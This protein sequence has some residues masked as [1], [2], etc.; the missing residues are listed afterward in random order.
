M[1]R[2]M[3]RAKAKTGFDRYVR[4]RM[5]D[6]EFARAYGDAKAEIEAVDRL[7]RELDQAR[8]R[9]QLSK[10]DLARRAR[11]PAESVRR[12]LTAKRS[13]PNLQ[14]VVRLARVVGLRMEFRPIRTTPP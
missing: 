5:Q 14:T 7:I 8:E 1:L 3:I 4:R 11:A 2:T 13:N 6:K 9:A 12:L 10:A